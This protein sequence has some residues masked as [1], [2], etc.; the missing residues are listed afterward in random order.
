MGSF[1]EDGAN[2]QLVQSRIKVGVLI[3]PSYTCDGLYN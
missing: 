2:K 1:Y 3:M